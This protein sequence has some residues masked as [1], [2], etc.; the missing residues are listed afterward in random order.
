MDDLIRFIYLS[1]PSCYLFVQI[2]RE[3]VISPANSR[4]GLTALTK[5]VGLMDRP[6]SPDSELIKYRVY[7]SSSSSSSSYIS[8]LAFA[9]R[10]LLDYFLLISLSLTCRL[11]FFVLV[12]RPFC[13]SG[14]HDA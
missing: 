11:T 2:A 10:C 5:R 4:L 14:Q 9:P 12:G 1:N 3:M 7:S 13:D 8:H 6:D